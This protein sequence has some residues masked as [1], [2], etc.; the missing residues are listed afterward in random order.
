MRIILKETNVNGKHVLLTGQPYLT[1]CKG[2]AGASEDW[3]A[4]TNFKVSITNSGDTIL[5]NE[6]L[7]LPLPDAYNL[8]TATEIFE[9]LVKSINGEK[10]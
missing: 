7:R 3:G 9:K 5:D 1:V 6:G 8:R 2:E 10:I 4:L